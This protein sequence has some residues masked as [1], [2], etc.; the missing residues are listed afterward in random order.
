MVTEEPYDDDD[1]VD[2]DEDDAD[3]PQDH[4]N[5]LAS[6]AKA[7][8]NLT[9]PMV[10]GRSSGEAE[11]TKSLNKSVDWPGEPVLSLEKYIMVLKRH[12]LSQQLRPSRRNCWIIPLRPACLCPP[13]ISSCLPLPPPTSNLLQP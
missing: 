11:K 12:L 7:A 13:I 1:L 6:A 10:A 2:I 8:L 4:Q 5:L 9:D 3:E